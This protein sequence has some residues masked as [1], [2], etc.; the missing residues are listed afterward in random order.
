MIQG[1]RLLTT[2]GYNINPG[3]WDNDAQKV[4]LTAAG[5]PVVN[6]RGVKAKVINAYLKRI[7]SYFS[8]LENNLLN[9][10]NSVGDIKTIFKTEFGR[11]G[12][13]NKHNEP[14]GFY[15][16][17]DEFTEEMGK[18]NDWT[19]STHEKFH[20]LK[21]HIRDYSENV[22]FDSFDEKGLTNFV[23]FMRNQLD[24]KNST[25]GKQLGFLK[26]F[27]KWANAKGYN[28][29]TAYRS[30]SPK[31]KATEKKVVFFDWDELMKIYEYDFPDVGTEIT[32]KDVNGKEYKKRVGLEKSTLER[33]RDVF[34]FCCFTSLRYSDVANLK[35]SNVFPG[36]IQITTVK[37]ADTLKIELNKYAASILKKYSGQSFPYERVLPVLSNQRMNEHLKDMA[38]IIGFNSP[39]TIT[40]YKGNE[41]I[42]EVYPKWQMIGTHTGR[43]TFICNAL[44]LSIA[45]QIVM[46]WTGHSDYK[47]MK[48][49]VDIA[50][51]AKADA[52]KLFDNHVQKKK[53]AKKKD[54]LTRKKK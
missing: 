37:T 35:R 19:P 22:S 31:L 4:L 20:A 32:L 33:V 42:D 16:Y 5:K 46:K 10:G 39:E 11:G 41:R 8:D 12:L 14:Q 17:F 2:T 53:K 47:A 51:R 44:M 1:Q 23:E 54:S 38:E 26:W 24:M 15:D 36:F 45:P 25:I 28:K 29:E 48:P 21:N 43:R 50:D 49:Y 7:D 30:F 40:Y 52:M 27:L 6:A 13:G 3:C 18:Q 9:T 34:C